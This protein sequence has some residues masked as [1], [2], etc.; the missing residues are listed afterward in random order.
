MP[1][2]LVFELP[3]SKRGFI[4]VNEEQYEL[5]PEKFNQFLVE[6]HTKKKGWAK[7][8]LAEYDE[9]TGEAYIPQNTYP[10]RRRDFLFE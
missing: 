5:L 8:E 3:D 6:V 4:V 1:F 10:L 2:A 9:L 7:F